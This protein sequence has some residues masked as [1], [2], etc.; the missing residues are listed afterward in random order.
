METG[1]ERR[2]TDISGHFP[3]VIDRHSCNKKAFQS[4][5]GDP[6]VTTHGHIQTCSLGDPSPLVNR[7]NDWQTDRHNCKP[8]LSAAWLA[9]SKFLGANSNSAVTASWIWEMDY[10]QISIPHTSVFNMINIL[11][12]TCA[13]TLV[14]LLLTM[15]IST[16]CREK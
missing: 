11:A 3:V 1:R 8:Y 4:K 7:Q 13:M 14:G 9:G 10:V 6:H 15:S 12:A 2:I 16:E 5:A